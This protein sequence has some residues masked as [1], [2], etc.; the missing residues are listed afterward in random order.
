MKRRSVNELIE[1]DSICK[2]SF[3]KKKNNH[4]KKP[5]LYLYSWVMEN[6]RFRASTRPQQM[7]QLPTPWVSMNPDRSK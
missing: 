2:Y 5:K 1:D 4:V 6:N 7:I 3:I